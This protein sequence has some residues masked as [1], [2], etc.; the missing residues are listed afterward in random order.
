MTLK[1][2]RREKKN[3]LCKI[4]TFRERAIKHTHEH[5]KKNLFVRITAST[6]IVNS[7]IQFPGWI[8]LPQTKDQTLLL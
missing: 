3:I 5:K 6:L 8:V 4:S 7:I 2:F 1:T